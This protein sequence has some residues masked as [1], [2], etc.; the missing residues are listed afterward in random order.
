MQVIESK[1]F[2][3]TS[4]TAIRKKLF[5]GIFACAAVLTAAQPAA[6]QDVVIGA[7][8]DWKAHSY[9]EPEGK[10][11]NMWSRPIKNE[12]S[13]VNRGDIYAFITHRPALN[14]F[15]AVSFQMGYPLNTSEEVSVQIGNQKFRLIPEGEAAFADESDDA[16][17]AAAMR[18]GNRMV[19]RG[20][21]TRGTRTIDTY[22]LSGVTA[23]TNALNSACPK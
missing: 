19:V 22:S 18:R 2:R 4:V 11:C 14:S 9:Q 17:I 21:S 6:A 7:Y 10:V 3:F 16:K 12:P 20:V 15:A 5:S 8:N 23:G 13:N 1:S